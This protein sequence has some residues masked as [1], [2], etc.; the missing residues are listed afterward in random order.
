MA[1]FIVPRKASI[2]TSRSFLMKNNFFNG[3][4]EKAILEFIP[5]LIDLE[6]IGLVMIAAWSAWC[7][8]NGQQVEVQ[9]LP[10]LGDYAE[11]N[12]LLQQIGI[13]NPQS[14]TEN[15]KIGCFLSLRNVKTQEDIRSVIN[16]VYS[17]LPL[18][19]NPDAL[20]AIQY[21]MSELLN[22][23]LEHSGS[24]DGAF[25]CAHN[26]TGKGPH[27]VSLAV[28]DCGCGITQH[29][30]KAYPDIRDDDLSALQHAMLPVLSGVIPGLYG[31]SNKVGDGLFITRCI[32]KAASGYF[33]II[34]GRA[35]YRL[36][37]ATIVDQSNLF[38]D[39]FLERSDQWRLPYPW[40]GTIVAIEISTKMNKEFKNFFEWIQDQ[41]LLKYLFTKG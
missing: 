11:L 18:I 30:S 27:R 9:N 7:N 32:A 41:I 8:R 21:C 15:Q 36:R 40:L 26:Y 24:P 2:H 13:K 35:A 12:R 31:S 3:F 19:N 16:D 6:P 34:S 23:S 5:N 17:L 20:A 29:L 1:K 28:A 37:R 22:N 14:K 38:R 39:A 10:K 4:D 25:I 33:E